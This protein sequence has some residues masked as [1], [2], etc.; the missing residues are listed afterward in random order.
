MK[1]RITK[2]IVF[3]LLASIS[4]SNLY[5]QKQTETENHFEDGYFPTGRSNVEI[6]LFIPQGNL[7]NNLNV[8]TNI[9]YYFG[10]QF[11]EKYALDLGTSIFIPN[12]PKTLNYYLEDSLIVG[13][14]ELSG[15]L[16][17]W[18][19]R[20]KKIHKKYTWENRFGTGLGFLQTDIPTGKPK[21]CNDESRGSATIFLNLGTSIKR[22]INSRKDIGIYVNYFYTPY[23]LFEKNLDKGF[24]N[25]YATVGISYGIN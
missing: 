6:G 20:V 5:A 19:S 12:K 18:L 11:N 23:N 9:S 3:I 17:L 2:K 15:T 13:K 4:I 7:R 22:K 8:S 1:K 16:G 24:G 14:P 21:E 25:Q 10:V